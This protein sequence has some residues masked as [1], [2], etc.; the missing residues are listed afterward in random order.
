MPSSD[1]DLEEEYDTVLFLLSRSTE[2]LNTYLDSD[3]AIL[4]FQ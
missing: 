4:Y 1:P 2:Q 3:F